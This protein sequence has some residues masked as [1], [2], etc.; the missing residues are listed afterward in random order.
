M[1]DVSRKV[2]KP[3]SFEGLNI[4]EYW[5]LAGNWIQIS[6]TLV[7]KDPT[8]CGLR[9]GFLSRRG[10]IKIGFREDYAVIGS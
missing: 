3:G 10:K 8:A 7:G 6:R 5:S 2:S 4:W 9:F 1:F